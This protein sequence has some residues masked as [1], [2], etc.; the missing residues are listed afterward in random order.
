[1]RRA[2]AALAFVA[3]LSCGSSPEPSAEVVESGFSIRGDRIG[4]GAIV[5]IDGDRALR[6]IVLQVTFR[7]GSTTLGV[8]TDTLPFCPPSTDC[9]WGRMLF[10]TELSPRW[11]DVDRVDIEVL[12]AGRTL[13]HEREIE[14]LPTREQ[15]GALE[16]RRNGREGTAYLIAYDG[17]TPR[18]GYSFFTERAEHG[19]LRYNEAIFPLE[20]GERFETTLYV[21]GTPT[22]SD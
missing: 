5:R 13:D 22:P 21:G 14:V 18:A 20:L 16:V 1:M 4:M 19:R 11:R 10:G 6:D 8:E 17:R 15:D 2:A 3:M 9:P 12:R 7:T